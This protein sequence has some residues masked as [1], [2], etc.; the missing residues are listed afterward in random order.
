MNPNTSQAD[1]ELATWRIVS[2]DKR[3][4]RFTLR[5]DAFWTDGTPVTAEDVVWAIQRNVQPE[6][7]I[8]PEE[9]AA[10]LYPLKNA[11]AIREG[12]LVDPSG[13]QLGVRAVDMLTVEFTLEQPI[14][15]F[16]L[17]VASDVYRP[18]P[19]HIITQYGEA[20][21]E[22]DTIVTN[23]PYRLVHWDKDLVMILQK[24]P[25]Y[26]AADQVAIPE[27]RLY[28]ISGSAIGMTM[29]QENKLDLL[30][31]AF[32]PIPVEDIA[33]IQTNPAL[34]DE[35]SVQP[36]SAVWF[37]GINT[38]RPPMDNPLVRK[39]IAA[40]ID[41]RLFTELITSGSRKPTTTITPPSVFG[42]IPPSEKVGLPFDPGQAR[43][44]LKE[45]GYPN[46]E[47]FPEITAT[48]LV[49]DLVPDEHLIAIQ[50]F[51]KHYLN[52]QVTFDFTDD[53]LPD[54]WIAYRRF[55]QQPDGPHLFL[56]GYAADYPDADNFLRNLFHPDSP[57]AL[58]SMLHWENQEFNDT[59]EAAL[60][61]DDAAR[62]ETYYTR[63]EQILCEED[64]VAIPFLYNTVPVL[65]KSR[66]K[67]WEYNPV[68]G[69]HMSSW[70]LE[71]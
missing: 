60:H 11:R 62:R 46:G 24:N 28:S 15:Y 13:E 68:G 36:D 33:H 14:P 61:T 29:Y 65:I 48:A 2:G 4:Y 6:T 17:L 1:P 26:Y 54:P 35:Y 22:Y 20:W 39:A 49:P 30:G 31:G 10:M 27:I 18:L 56:Y 67:G 38:A 41:R 42:A 71:G 66:V 9:M 53:L 45:A 12:R 40:A 70:S 59:V 7:K 34:K 23:G 57:N 51:L 50:T 21:T 55:I 32:L 5:D 63:A 58:N 19:R 43:Q 44:W 69:Q 52:I 64:V 37:F 16:P 3:V 47:R 8:Q 25:R